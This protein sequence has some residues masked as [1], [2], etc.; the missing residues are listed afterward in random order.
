MR[1][2]HQLAWE[3]ASCSKMKLQTKIARP[4]NT[5]EERLAGCDTAHKFGMDLHYWAYGG[6]PAAGRR[7]RSWS[8]QNPAVLDSEATAKLDQTRS[9]STRGTGSLACLCLTLGA[10]WQS[11]VV[12]L[13]SVP[14]ESAGTWTLSEG[15][16]GVEKRAGACGRN[17]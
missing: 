2:I 11:P 5:A 16:V 17:N 7:R 3:G 12:H 15:H 9:A 4:V 6:T 1:N 8:L 14:G 13:C 10:S